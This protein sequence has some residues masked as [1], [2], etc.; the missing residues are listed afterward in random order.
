[1][2]IGTAV[3]AAANVLIDG[4]Q[5]PSATLGERN[6]LRLQTRVRNAGTF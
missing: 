1:M 5:G 4:W 2:L 6:W 3:A